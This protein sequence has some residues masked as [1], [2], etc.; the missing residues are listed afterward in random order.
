MKLDLCDVCL[1]EHKLTLTK[2]KVGFTGAGRSSV[3]EKHK[4]TFKGLDRADHARKQLE[5]IEKA[6]KFLTE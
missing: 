5:L 2:Y 6:N 1:T 3:C 4:S